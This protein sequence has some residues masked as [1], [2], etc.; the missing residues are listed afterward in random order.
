MTDSDIN[1]TVSWNCIKMC[2]KKE[3]YKMI[4]LRKFEEVCVKIKTTNLLVQLFN[5]IYLV[6]I[7]CQVLF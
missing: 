5:N 1:L 7:T 2:F 4:V 6:A 3:A